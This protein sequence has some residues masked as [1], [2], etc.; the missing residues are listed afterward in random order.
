MRPILE[1]LLCPG[2]VIWP[3]PLSP[4]FGTETRFTRNRKYQPEIAGQK[5]REMDLFSGLAMYICLVV[6]CVKTFCLVGAEI[7]L[8]NLLIYFHA[9]V[10]VVV[11]VC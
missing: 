1:F 5:K 6:G 11:M 8:Q 7:L 3:T 9:V 10:V 4:P 2:T